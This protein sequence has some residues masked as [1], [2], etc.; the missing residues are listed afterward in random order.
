MT[1]TRPSATA[2]RFG[3]S[4]GGVSSR[5]AALA[6]RSIVSEKTSP[7]RPIGFSAASGSRGKSSAG[8]V[9]RDQP[10]SLSEGSELLLWLALEGVAQ[11]LGVSYTIEPGEGDAPDVVRLPE[12][13]QEPYVRPRM[14]E[15]TFVPQVF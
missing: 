1:R 13:R 4:P 10:T 6:T 7:A 11:G 2:T 9:R 8:N 3:K 12:M 14:H 15:Q 5:D